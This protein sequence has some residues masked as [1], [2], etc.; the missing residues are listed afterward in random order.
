MKSI[1]TSKNKDIYNCT[2][3]LKILQENNKKSR[4][5]LW[6]LLCS[7]AWD[8]LLAGGAESLTTLILID[9]SLSTEFII[10]WRSGGQDTLHDLCRSCWTWCLHSLESY[11]LLLKSVKHIRI[12]WVGFYLGGRLNNSLGSFKNTQFPWIQ[13]AG[14]VL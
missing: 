7:S 14:C 4:P 1:S 13:V 10:R 9:L 6:F 2:K 12:C 11:V 5:N 3:M 8:L